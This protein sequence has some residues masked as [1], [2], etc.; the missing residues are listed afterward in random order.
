[1]KRKEID[2]DAATEERRGQERRRDEMR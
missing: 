2:I 1:M